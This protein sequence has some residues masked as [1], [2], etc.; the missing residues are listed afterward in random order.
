MMPD[1]P[2]IE[3]AKAN[4]IN[5]SEVGSTGMRGLKTMYIDISIQYM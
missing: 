3:L 2:E 4:R 1:T 5:Y